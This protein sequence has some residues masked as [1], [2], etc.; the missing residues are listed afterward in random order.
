MCHTTTGGDTGHD[1][2]AAADSIRECEACHVRD[3]P[4]YGA[5]DHVYVVGSTRSV[6]LDRVSQFG[7]VI[8]L[9]VI[10]VH[11][12]RRRVATGEW[13]QTHLLHLA[14]P[15][16]IKVWHTLQVV[17]FV[18]LVGSGLSMHYGDSGLAPLPFRGAVLT[19][20]AFGVANVILWT[21]FLIVNHRTGNERSY[22]RR[23]RSTLEE[24]RPALD[25][26][27]R[28]VFRGDPSPGPAHPDERFNPLQGISYL[29]VMYV[30]MPTS[31]VS[32][33]FLLFPVLAPERALGHPGLWPAAMAHLAMAYAISLFVAVHLYMVLS[34]RGEPPS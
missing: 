34:D 14:G 9:L 6:V 7:F 20:N 12:V 31:V 1:M 4:A 2:R 22:L 23:L 18:G 15:R 11:S 10:L 8:F 28:G 32:G 21:V 3:D 24:I 13:E 19:H 16:G 27:A 17:L 25:Y 30:V 5:L 26:Y 33:T 29:V